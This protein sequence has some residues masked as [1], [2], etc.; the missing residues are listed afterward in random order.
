MRIGAASPFESP[1]AGLDV[2]TTPD[3]RSQVLHVLIETA[4]AC[5]CCAML[6]DR[7]KSKFY[8]NLNKA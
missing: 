3:I 7:S 2:P 8:Q 5:A 4:S 1:V 6:T